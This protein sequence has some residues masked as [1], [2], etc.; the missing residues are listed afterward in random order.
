[1]A[2]KDNKDRGIFQKRG[3]WWINYVDQFGKEHKEKVGP[4]K[5][6]ARE[7]YMA[8]K[9]DVRAGKFHPGDVA[10]RRKMTVADAI[11][12]Y[13]EESR[14]TKRTWKWDERFGTVWI[15]ELG[16]EPLDA[17]KPADIEAWRRRKG[18][19]ASPA[20][21][22]RHVAFLKRV[23]NVAIRDERCKV[24]PV[25]RIKM[26]RENNAR[27]QFLTHEEEEKLRASFPADMW[28]FVELAIQTGLRQAEQLGL[29]WEHVDFANGVLTIPR[30]KHG[31][32]RH[33][34][35]NPR[36]KE[37]LRAMPSRMKSP[38][39]YPAKPVEEKRGRRASE[40]AEHLTYWSIRPAFDRAVKVAGMGDF[41]WHDLR[42]SFASRLIMKGVDLRT[43]QEL[44]GHKTILMTQR[45]AHLAP[46][47]LQ[48]AVDLLCQSDHIP[49]SDHNR[50][51]TKMTPARSR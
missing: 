12:A 18:Q 22:N 4:S 2:R 28:H 1:M 24:N 8:R 48:A 29:R 9:A 6:E 19:T 49:E 43:V 34:P 35:M 46:S 7:A 37:I 21:V 15:A 44:M 5:T 39:V 25:T 17:V 26:H 20:T 51:K 3:D 31:E 42:H 32:K 11:K 27:L 38:W 50:T 36:V 45:Y 23:F 10:H 40:E 41:H 33:I 47:H 14:A 13:L 30:A 16:D